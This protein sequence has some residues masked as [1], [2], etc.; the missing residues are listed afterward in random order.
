MA[1]ILVAFIVLIGIAVLVVVLTIDKEWIETRL[2]NILS[3]QVMIG[4]LKTR[5]L[6]P[7]SGFQVED[8]KISNR[9]S[10]QKLKKGEE[11]PADRLFIQARLGTIKLSLLPLL[12]RKL[13]I[14]EILLHKPSLH[15]IRY[16]NGSYNFSDLM[17]DEESFFK[18]I[19]I[20]A[21]TIRDGHLTFTDQGSN[22]RFSLN[23]FTLNSKGP[24]ETIGK[25]KQE[26]LDITSTFIFRA[27]QLRSTSFAKEAD[28][29]FRIDGT[30]QSSVE[31]DSPRLS[32][33]LDVQ[34]LEGTI[35]GFKIMEKIN[36]IPVIREY[37]GGLDF[38]SR[39]FTWEKGSVRI[40]FD[41][42]IIKV[43]GGEIRARN[44]SLKYD[45]QFR[46]HSGLMSLKAQLLLPA[47]YKESIRSHLLAKINRLLPA[48][49][50]RS[51]DQAELAEKMIS[52][53]INQQGQLYLVFALKGTPG[54]PEVRLIRPRLKQFSKVLLDLVKEKVS[55][56]GQ[57]LLDRLMEKVLKKK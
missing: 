17:D 8:L 19:S 13:K 41:E 5:V 18:Q 1:G 14:R 3:R 20:S 28:I 43:A 45:G 22:N 31:P 42:G 21:L 27:R 26:K 52:P 37:L 49:W 2:Q 24:G 38:L 34:T 50:K 29:T 16:R 30:I 4:K 40:G 48:R 7:I 32:F 51:V 25:E 56:Q 53:I 46:P 36:S 23:D 47:K 44:H 11:I 12:Q 39:N 35:Q 15:I 55:S 33:D 54:H 10:P 57:S 9:L 6:S